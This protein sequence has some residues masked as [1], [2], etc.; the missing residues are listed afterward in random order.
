MLRGE[1]AKTELNFFSKAPFL[2]KRKVWRDEEDKKDKIRAIR[3]AE[4]EEAE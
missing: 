2:K 3:M 1:D 4:E